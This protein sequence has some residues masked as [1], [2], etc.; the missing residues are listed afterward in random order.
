MTKLTAAER[1]A[2]E[3]LAARSWLA[4]AHQTDPDRC[5]IH[6]GTARRLVERGLA[7]SVAMMPDGSIVDGA[8]LARYLGYWSTRYQITSQGRRALRRVP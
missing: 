6:G 4:G 3:A 7:R 5:D 8:D 1:R 2:L